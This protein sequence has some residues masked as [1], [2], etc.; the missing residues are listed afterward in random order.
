MAPLRCS[1]R[2]LQLHIL[3]ITQNWRRLDGYHVITTQHDDGD[4]HLAR[5]QR[6]KRR[7][8][9]RL[10]VHTNI[11]EAWYPSVRQDP[12]WCT[13]FCKIADHDNGIV[14]GIEALGLAPASVKQP[15][16]EMNPVHK[17]VRIDIAHVTMRIAHGNMRRTPLDGAQDNR[18]RIARHHPSE[19]V[20]P[21]KTTKYLLDPLYSGSPFHIYRDEYFHDFLPCAR[22]FRMFAQLFPSNSPKTHKHIGSSF[23]FI[24]SKPKLLPDHH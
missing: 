13:G 16:P 24:L 18:I 2:F 17:I 4:A 23:Y 5:K 3:D 11:S 21:G 6:I 12:V 10:S 14:A 8:R 7:L 15:T 19:K 22:T 9:D 1:D 20:K